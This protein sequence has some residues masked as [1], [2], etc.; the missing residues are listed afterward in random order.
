MS[1]RLLADANFNSRIV[2]GLRKR[3]PAVDF[4]LPPRLPDPGVLA[5]A[6]NLGRVLV[7]HDLG[8]MPRHF[9]HLL[10]RRESP[11][12]ILIANTYPV[13]SAIQQLALS[14]SCSNADEFR[15][16]ITWLPY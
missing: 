1:A 15:N 12:L 9:Y 4:V 2:Y 11:G 7:S 8:T 3:I 10:A 13:G 6:A 5:L 14:W 16:R